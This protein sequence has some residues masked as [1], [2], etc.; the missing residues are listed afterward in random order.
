MPPRAR[1]NEWIGRSPC[2]FYI[3]PTNATLSLASSAPPW[4]GSWVG[5][6][7]GWSSSH[8]ELRPPLNLVDFQQT[9]WRAL[10][11]ALVH[12]LARHP[13]RTQDVAEA[14]FC[15]VSALGPPVID[16]RFSQLA[17]DTPWA[18]VCPSSTPLVVI[19]NADVDYPGHPICPELWPE[20]NGLCSTS[21]PSNSTVS[22]ARHRC[23]KRTLKRTLRITGGAPGLNRKIHTDCSNHTL[24][25]P[26]LGHARAAP[27]SLTPNRPRPVRIAVAMGV[28]G[29]FQ[30]NAL[31]FTAWRLALRN[32][33]SPSLNCTRS[34]VTQAGTNTRMAIG[35][36][37]SPRLNH[38]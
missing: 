2:Q 21:K 25:V 30:A 18:H 1:A 8:L 3:V 20:V 4:G 15:V 12:A 32:A 7:R 26:W 35:N 19:E 31:G 33:C 22:L 14:C 28:I 38:K 34:W 5:A 36:C 10:P 17:C 9:N 29:H 24:T 6:S 11:H 37:R 13:S 16:P 23:C 27:A